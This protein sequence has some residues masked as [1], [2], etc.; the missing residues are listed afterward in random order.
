[1]ITY[2]LVVLQFDNIKLEKKR[3]KFLKILSL[4]IIYDKIIISML[5][6]KNKNKNTN[7]YKENTKYK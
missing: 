6:Y 5:F 1:V 2:L 7:I 3:V 4:F